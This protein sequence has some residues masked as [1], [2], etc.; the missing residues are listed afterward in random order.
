MSTPPSSSAPSSKASLSKKKK[1]ISPNLKHYANQIIESQK[2]RHAPPLSSLAPRD[3]ELHHCF[4]QK[5]TLQQIAELFA[6]ST[7]GSSPPPIASSSSSS[8][9]P[10]ITVPTVAASTPAFIGSSSNF[11]LLQNNQQISGHL[12]PSKPIFREYMFKMR[13]KKNTFSREGFHYVLGMIWENFFFYFPPESDRELVQKD[14]SKY[15]CLG[16]LYLPGCH[17]KASSLN[18]PDSLVDN[19]HSVTL[20]SCV[21]RKKKGD[22]M[23]DSDARTL[24]LGFDS[25]EQFSRFIRLVE[26]VAYPEKSSEVK[27]E[28]KELGLETIQD[29][30]QAVQDQE[31]GG[32][33]SKAD[34]A[35]DDWLVVDDDEED[36]FADV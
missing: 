28:M 22:F 36:E 19:K 17:I 6:V 26:R 35:N 24:Q 2:F 20:R 13:V 18:Q 30:L 32:P 3:P 12:P 1:E 7:N 33:T 4:M 14:F 15:H 5:P 16:S 11:N 9:S 29:L 23:N 34:K 27:E 21:P 31:L 8:S 10:Q 25:S